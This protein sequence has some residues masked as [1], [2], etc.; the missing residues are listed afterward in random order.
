MN[1]KTR[2]KFSLRPEA[3]VNIARGGVAQSVRPA[4]LIQGVM[5]SNP[6]A[7]ISSVLPQGWGVGLHT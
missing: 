3:L 7:V 5:G 4:T 6:A 1:N 2:G